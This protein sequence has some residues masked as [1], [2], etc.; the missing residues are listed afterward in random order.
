[1]LGSAY[2]YEN[3]GLN[4]GMNPL[5]DFMKKVILII[6]KTN[7]SFLQ[8]DDLLEY[9]NMV[10]NSFF[11]RGY[12]YSKLKD[13]H[14]FDEITEYNKRNM[15]IVYPDKTA[16]PSNPSGLLAREIGCHMVAMRYQ[17][18]DSY[19][20]NNNSFFDNCGYAFCLKPDNLRYTPKTIDPPTAQNPEYSYA[21]KTQTTDYYSINY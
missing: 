19:L 15:T 14:G 18:V 7:D 13:I 16:N 20:E 4:L 11:M 10:S 8:N 2:S 1:M 21:T 9:V 5:L 12:E 3:N 17:H 6:D